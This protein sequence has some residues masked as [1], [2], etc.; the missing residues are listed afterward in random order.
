MHSLISSCQ[1]M[2]IHFLHLVAAVV[3]NRSR[4]MQKKFQ[5]YD[6]DISS[7]GVGKYAVVHGTMMLVMSEAECML[8]IAVHVKTTGLRKSDKNDIMY[9]RT[10]T[11]H[12]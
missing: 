1:R 7:A 4:K 6:P 12:E 2:K 3:I 11:A 9:E 5:V 10:R 8:P